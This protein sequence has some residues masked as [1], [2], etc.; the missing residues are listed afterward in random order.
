MDSTIHLPITRWEVDLPIS[1]SADLW[2]QICTNTFTMTNNTNLQ[3]IQFIT[4]YSTR[5]V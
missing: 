4:Y 5:D 2:Q 3:L 1:P